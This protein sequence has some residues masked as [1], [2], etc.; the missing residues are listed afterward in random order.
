MKRAFT[1]IELL[2][3]IAIIAIL[4]AILF[5]VFAQAKAAAKKAACL[6]N[7]KQLGVMTALYQG[8]YDDIFPNALV[9]STI[10]SGNPNDPLNGN[11]TWVDFTQPYMKSKDVYRCPAE[12]E[13][14]G[15]PKSMSFAVNYAYNFYI[16]GTQSGNSV[17][18]AGVSGT[19]MTEPAGTVLLT[20]GGVDPWQAE[21]LGK[22]P[23]QWTPV[24][25]TSGSGLGY[26]RPWLLVDS[27]EVL[28][29]Y[30]PSSLVFKT[31][32]YGAPYAR[33]GGLTN[34]LWCDTHAGSRRI[35]SFYRVLS[36]PDTTRPASDDPTLTPKYSPCLHP[37]IGC[38]GVR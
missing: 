33:H 11:N 26:Y 7:V 24:L 2:V 22:K 30:N 32:A 36:D 16:G 5:P 15:H 20:E 28:L 3:V 18:R 4:A 19:A 14:T 25:V 38:G 9:G 13:A 8:D 6:S 12:G 1:L 29:R 21:N 17:A 23:A 10:S 37:E 35:E 34:V 31:S 27:T